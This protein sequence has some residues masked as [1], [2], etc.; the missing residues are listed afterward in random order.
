MAPAS[1]AVR[2]SS[3]E[4]STPSPTAYNKG[5]EGSNPLPSAFW[6]DGEMYITSI[7]MDGMADFESVGRGSIPRRNAQN[8]SLECAGFAREPAKLVDQV[9]FLAGTLN[10]AGAGWPGGCLQSS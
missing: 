10:D 9:R 7:V 1:K 6:L 8:M 3:L 2:A 5:D 4:G